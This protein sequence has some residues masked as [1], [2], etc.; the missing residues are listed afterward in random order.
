V[1]G[2]TTKGSIVM[3]N[4]K[5]SWLNRTRNSGFVEAWFALFEAT[6]NVDNRW[7]RNYFFVELLLTGLMAALAGIRP[8]QEHCRTIAGMVTLISVLQLGFLVAVRPYRTRLDTVFTIFFGA[9]QV[10]LGVLCILATNDDKFLPYAA[11]CALVSMVSLMVQAPM[12]LAWAIVTSQRRKV[13]ESIARDQRR[14]RH[15]LSSGSTRS[16][17]SLGE[18][19]SPN[20]SFGS[21]G[22]EML[23][24]PANPLHGSFTQ[25]PADYDGGAPISNDS[26]ASYYSDVP[27]ISSSTA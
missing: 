21:Q 9:V 22:K 15:S 17:S 7:A 1:R 24:V 16:S 3:G 4:L 25:A 26:I 10:A 23:V 11:T 8:P 18:E 14:Q 6:R 12:Q 19:R 5:F 20:S 2:V 13:T 27:S